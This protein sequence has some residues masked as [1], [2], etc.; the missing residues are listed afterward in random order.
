MMGPREKSTTQIEA[1]PLNELRRLM[2]VVFQGGSPSPL[3]PGL[4]EES[5]L[6]LSRVFENS[7]NDDF[8]D[9]FRKVLGLMLTSTDPLN[10]GY[11]RRILSTAKMIR[12]STISDAL[13]EV[14]FRLDQQPAPME[15]DD[16]RRPIRLLVLDA[17]AVQRQN[18]G[19]GT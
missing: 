11:G 1:L 12:S 9:R 15:V 16:L 19:I 5:Y 6:A 3:Q 17:L 13:K 7:L 8:L 2:D 18:L 4:N 14:L 10:G